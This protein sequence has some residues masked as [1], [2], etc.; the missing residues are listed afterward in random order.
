MMHKIFKIIFLK[1]YT[2]PKIHFIFLVPL[3]YTPLLEIYCATLYKKQNNLFQNKKQV[4]LKGACFLF[5]NRLF[6]FLYSVAQYIS[7][8]GVYNRGT[9][10]IKCIFGNVYIFKKIILNILCIIV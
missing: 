1:I 7:R 5:W 2:F 9:R 3:L 6:C 8:R 4:S 10:K